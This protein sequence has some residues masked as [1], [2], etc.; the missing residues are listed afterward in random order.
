MRYLKFLMKLFADVWDILVKC[1]LHHNKYK[2]LVSPSKH[3]KLN[4]LI[5]ILNS[6]TPYNTNYS[7]DEKSRLYQ[8]LNIIFND[9]IEI[10]EYKLH[11]NSINSSIEVEFRYDHSE[12][13][14][15][16]LLITQIDKY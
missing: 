12:S 8:L 6:I 5:S 16:F 13:C 15:D 4:S 10:C 9:F 3:S 7:M 1:K 11:Q 2:V 14:K